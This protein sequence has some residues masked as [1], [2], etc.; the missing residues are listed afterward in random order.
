MTTDIGGGTFDR[1]GGVALAPDGDILA[2]GATGPGCGPT[3]CQFAFGL[4]RYEGDSPELEVAVDIKPG[5]DDNRVTP[6]KG[7]IPVAIVTTDAFDATAVEPASICFG[8]AETPS[9]RTCTEVHGRGHVEDVNADRRTDLVVHF[10][11]AASGIDTGDDSA[12]LSG[13]TRD[14]IA[15]RGCDSIRTH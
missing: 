3:G 6:D 9:E 10:E 2:A 8:D 7:T 5:S 11:A 12:C 14:G 4:V 13:R 1:L 15:V